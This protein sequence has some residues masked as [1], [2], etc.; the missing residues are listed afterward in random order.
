MRYELVVSLLSS[1]VLAIPFI[2]PSGTPFKHTLNYSVEKP[3][4]PPPPVFEKMCCWGPISPNTYGRYTKAEK[5]YIR[6]QTK[7]DT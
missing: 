7:T 6:F 5:K 1:F 4:H 2:R 3:L